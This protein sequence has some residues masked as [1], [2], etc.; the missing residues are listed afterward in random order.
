MA[1]MEEVHSQMMEITSKQKDKVDELSS[2]IRKLK[3]MIVKHES[4]I[5]ALET[6]NREL[7]AAAVAAAAA[8]SAASDAPDGNGNATGGG[9]GGGG[10]KNGAG[11]G[12]GD[13]MDP[14]E[15]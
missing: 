15:V 13:E 2:E 10:S 7:E 3:A 9:G 5:R 4:R 11:S 6:K 12:I 8:V 1:V 14:D